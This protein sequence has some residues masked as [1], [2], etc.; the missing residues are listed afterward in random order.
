MFALLVNSTFAA[1]FT[2]N[3]SGDASDANLSDLGPPDSGKLAHYRLVL[4]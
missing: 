3:D 2:V 4:S 1:V